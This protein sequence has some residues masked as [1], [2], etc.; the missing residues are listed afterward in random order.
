MKKRVSTFV[1]LIFLLS[2]FLFGQATATSAKIIGKVTDE[3]GNPLPGVAVTAESP[4]LV[5][6]ASTITDDKGVYRLLALQPGEYTLTFTLQGF[7]TVVRKDIVLHIDETLT[8]NIT[9]TPGKIEEEITVTGMAPLIDVRSTT[10]GMTI[11]KQMFEVLPRGRNFDTLVTAVPGVNSE[12]WLGGISVDGASAAENMV[13]IDGTDITRNDV[14]L[15]RIGAAFEF[16]DEIQVVA[17]GYN[18][19][20]GGALGGVINVVTR[21]GGNEYHGE[22]IGFYNSHWMRGTER[23]ILRL[24]PYNQFI[25]EYVNY[26]TGKNLEATVGKLGK[27]KYMRLEP[28]FSLGGYILK[29]KLWFFGSFLPVFIKTTGHRVFLTTPKQEGDFTQ[30]YTYYNFT[31]RITS[32]PLRFLRVGA[33]YVNNFYKYRGDLPARDGTSSPT[34]PWDKYGWDYPGYT[35][36]AFADFTFGNNFMIN[37]RGGRFFYDTTNQQVK[38][39]EPRWYHGGAGTAVF[40]QIPADYQRP[41]LWQNYGRLYEYKKYIKYKNNFDANFTY[42]FD[43]KGEHALKF[44]FSWVRQGEDADRTITY[45]EVYLYWDRTI[46]I[47]GVNYGRGIYGYYEVRG[48]KVTGPFGEYF[49]VYNDRWAL[50]IQDSWTIA[51]K[52]TLNL[53]I[54]TEAEEV[55]P[56]SD[57][58]SIPKGFKPIDFD[59]EEKLAPRIGFIYD[60]YGDASLKIFG[61]WG[62]YYDVIKTYMAAHSYAGFKWK[63]AYYTLDT[64]EWNKIGVNDY[65][66]GELRLVYDWRHPSFETTDPNLKPVSQREI[67]LGAEKKLIEN[68]SLTVR[69]VQKH[70]RYTIEDVG[71][72]TP[73]G[74]VYFECNPGY[75]YSI[76]GTK[77]YPIDPKYWPCPRAKREYY[78]VNI[79]F[80]KRLANNWLGGFSYTWSRL[81]GN[82]SGLGSSDEYGRTSPYVERNFD[83]WAM[84]YDKSG[85]PLDGPLPTDRP[86]FFKLYGAYSFPFGLTVGAVTNAMSGTPFTE[87]WYYLN[88]S[89]MYPFNRYYYRDEQGNL[90]RKRTP[91]LWFT[92]MY[93]VYNFR[94]GDRF[95][96]SIDLNV[97]NVFNI[98]TA[99]RYYDL[100]M[101]ANM[102]VSEAMVLSKNWD[103]T[104]PGINYIPDPRFMMKMEFYPPI[105]ARLGFKFSF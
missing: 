104:T 86:H 105:S 67:S 29:D 18:A 83:N 21:Q 55:P 1:C 44:G 47:G 32:Q 39:T 87:R 57:D 73:Y 56:Y 91:F 84:S 33:S 19:E 3:T 40:P 93:A 98:K 24:N 17:S 23:D 99:R 103:L 78:A 48:S 76:T 42:Y 85:K 5:G 74:E 95:R 51:D 12:P 4:K 14:G 63:S 66:P 7:N 20:Y 59:F 60:V 65:W 10:K 26:E 102:T 101:Q 88:V 92:N 16:A 43:L 90:K 30:K 68:L 71:V 28:G 89:T 58:P 45:P 70:L 62:L 50:F 75:G 97:D 41:R 31:G 100:K 81:E 38:S 80:D 52:F 53:G 94:L 37:L 22:I 35:F 82:Y 34:A 6:K 25:A 15:P 61:H 49:N 69:F 11:T 64:Y 77:E 72:L 13:Y 8:V 36:S 79:S 2:P 27:D 96:V 54:R 46:S 9:M